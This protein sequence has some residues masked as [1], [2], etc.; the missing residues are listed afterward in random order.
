[1]ND[2]EDRLVANIELHHSTKADDVVNIIKSLQHDG[3]DVDYV[4]HPGDEEPD[5]YVTKEVFGE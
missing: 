3:Y 1:M 5:I 2:T 4:T